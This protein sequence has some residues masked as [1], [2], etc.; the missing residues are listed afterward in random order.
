MPAELNLVSLN[1]A[2]ARYKCSTRTMRRMIAR[3][4][5][6]GYRVGPKL[7][8]IDTVEA[9]RLFSGAAQEPDA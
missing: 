2:A 7:I 8:R 9:D 4:D 3:G 6:I 5:L 1:D